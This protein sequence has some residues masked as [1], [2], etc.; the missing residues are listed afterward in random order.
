MAW[1]DE[2]LKMLES[3]FDKDKAFDNVRRIYENDRY[4]DFAHF[5]KTAEA[6]A[7]LMK[8][9][10]MEEVELLPLKAD[11]K[12]RYGD[13]VLPRAWDAYDAKLRV[14]SPQ[15]SDGLLCDYSINPCSLMMTSGGTPE[16]GIIAEVIDV[17]AA[18]D[19]G[20][21]DLK[22]KVI[23][24][25]RY[26]AEWFTPALEKGAIGIIND[27]FPIYE[28]VRDSASEMSGHSRWDC[29][30]FLPSNETGMVGFNLSPE[31][32]G[33]LREL[34]AKGSVT[35]E[36]K[37]NVKQYDGVNYTVSGFIPGSDPD[38]EEVMICGHLYEPGANDNATGCGAAIE[39]AAS[40]N[41]MIAEGILP[42]PK[43]GIRVILGY[44]ATGLVAYA[45]AHPDILAR[46]VV[47]LNLD[48]IGSGARDKAELKIVQNPASA[49][50]FLDV[51][52]PAISNHRIKGV[53]TPH[54]IENSTYS[55]PALSV[56]T[57]SMLMHPAKSY[58]STMDDMS[59]VDVCVLAKNSV[60]AF[61]AML[62]C[63]GIGE[64]SAEE[65]AEMVNKNYRHP[66]NFT[67][68]NAAYLNWLISKQINDSFEKLFNK[69]GGN[70]PGD[71]PILYSAVGHMAERIPERLVLGSLTL[72]GRYKP[73][74]W[75]AFNPCFNYN[76]NCPLYWTDG[77]RNMGEI[78][79]LTAT[80][81]C[82][83]DKNQY[84]GE[85]VRYYDML[86]DMGYIK[87]KDGHS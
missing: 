40:V 13:W 58:H 55:D 68:E 61:A 80:E 31:A 12:T 50:S 54:V 47:C 36:M 32:G 87:Y 74:E 43:R 70:P 26:Q 85:L 77:K 14:V 38:G 23:F 83:P 75:P 17:D 9:A 79:A 21:L 46:S 39:I 78:A 53:E 16:E 20:Q 82:Y 33:K 22:G 52:L 2:F 60:V 4:F 64:K 7:E 65:A 30:F 56:P 44:E 45:E 35:L 42:R 62:I 24:T 10:G 49:Y 73:G 5:N 84:L 72:R 63:A 41:R 86:F 48:M 28:N 34:L 6:V 37:V 19:P 29:D 76:L 1:I 11:G 59:M 81:L 15:V 18:P 3:V 25:G 27:F 69:P 66:S 71:R 51:L 67:G 57:V 8:E